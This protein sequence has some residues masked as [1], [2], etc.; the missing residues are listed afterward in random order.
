[1]RRWTLKARGEAMFESIGKYRAVIEIGFKQELAYK[2]DYLVALVFRMLCS[3]VMIF[4]W[5]TVF[6]NSGVA[7]IGGYSLNE[8]YLYFFIVNAITIFTYD[9]TPAYA[10]QNDVQNGNITTSL[11]R[12]LGYPLQ[13]F[14][15]TLAINALGLLC[16]VLPSMAIIVFLGRMSITPLLLA[17]FVAEILLAYAITTIINFLM[18]TLS[19]YLVNIWG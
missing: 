11:I 3:L 10:I 6:A 14:L 8:M 19:I 2:S 13:L 9:N 16:V 4:V 5:I 12:P 15:N 18:G 17:F 7:T 1:M